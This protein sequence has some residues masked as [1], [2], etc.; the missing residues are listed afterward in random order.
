M[1][2]L[3][4]ITMAK[5]FF[6]RKYLMHTECRHKKSFSLTLMVSRGK[7]CSDPKSGPEKVPYFFF[8]PNILVLYIIGTRKYADFKNECY[9]SLIFNVLLLFHEVHGH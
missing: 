2:V 6:G 5:S 1:G 8:S 4:N 9:L 3:L 7:N